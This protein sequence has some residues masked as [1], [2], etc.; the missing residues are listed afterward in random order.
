MLANASFDHLDPR[1]KVRP[2]PEPSVRSL[3]LPRAEVSAVAVE[4]R[5][6]DVIY[7]HEDAAEFV[8]EVV[9]G[10]VRT[11]L[12]SNEGRRVVRGFFTPG[13]VFGLTRNGR[14][15]SSA[16]AVSAATV[17]R[18]G[19]RRLESLAL[20]DPIMAREL[21]AWLLV[22]GERTTA[23]LA[24]LTHARAVERIAYFLT[25]M[26]ERVGEADRLQLPMSRYDIGDYLGL[27]S[28]TVSRAFTALRRRGLISTYGRAVVLL[29][30]D[31]LQR[32]AA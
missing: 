13:D 16:E 30:P 21:W 2:T 24:L 12:L 3:R 8:Y 7:A 27:S 9:E 6:G 14:H 28:E 10:M 18:C 4:L 22:E 15:E 17:A 11:V 32:L 25:E 29:R 20:V 19:R 23:R 31:L 5:G 1:R 26:A